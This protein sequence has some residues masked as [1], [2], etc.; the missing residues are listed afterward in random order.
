MKKEITEQLPIK[1][2]LEYNEETFHRLAESMPLLVWIA[3]TDGSI[4]YINSHIHQY[5][6]F[7]HTDDGSWDWT[8]LIHPDDLERTQQAW[9]HVQQQKGT[10][11][12]EHRLQCRDG[13][14]RWSQT[15]AVPSLSTDGQVLRWFGTTTDIDDL[16]RNEERLS[17]ERLKAEKANQSKSEFLANMTHDLRTPLTVI[18][19]SID[20]LEQAALSDDE[21]TCLDL[22]QTAS[23]NLLELIGGVL[24]FSKIEAGNF[25]LQEEAFDL[26]ESLR[27]TIALHEHK[28]LDDGLELT[29]E[30]ANET[31]Q[32][33]L[34]DKV[35]LQKVLSNLLENAI[36]F[37]TKGHITLAVCSQCVD[38]RQRVSGDRLLFSV[39]DS[40][41]GIDRENLTE[42]FKIFTKIDSPENKKQPIG[43]G[44]GLAICKEIVEKM[45]GDLWVESEPGNGSTFFVSLPMVIDRRKNPRQ[46]GDKD[47]RKKVESSYRRI[48]LAEDDASVQQVMRMMLKQT[49]G[50]LEI[51]SD[52]AAAINAWREKE[53]DLI[54]MDLQMDHMDGLSATKIIRNEEEHSGK[55]IPIIALT[56]HAVDELHEKCLVSGMDDVLIKPVKFESL[57]NIIATYC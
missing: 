7:A 54:L 50:E 53:F 13:S 5:R 47:G 37:T 25:S 34:S 23:N 32:I 3:R 39:R 14:Y 18:Q 56:A 22:A 24:D 8:R 30:I 12:I 1:T 36:K 44:L 51:V 11:Q 35:H 26:Y 4:E 38:F 10:Y 43:T 45:G 48:L 16:K 42:I 49:G 29:L 20:Y 6:G 52:G 27:E 2:P 21:R 9:Q 17:I 31:P 28:V 33:V 15:R 55:R 46:Q 19:G 41:C 57:S 40:G